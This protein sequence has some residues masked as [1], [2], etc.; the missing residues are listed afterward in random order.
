MKSHFLFLIL[1]SAALQAQVDPQ[2]VTIARDQFG[3]PHIFAKTD[4]EVS[5]GLAWAHAEDDFESLQKVALPSKGLMA[6]V[7]GRGGVGADYAFALFRCREITEEK[8]TTLSP[9]FI[10]LIQGYVQ[11]LNDY[12]QRHP[13]EVLHKDLF[14]ITL[15]DYIAS[16]VLALTVFN[17]GDRALSAIFSNR[18]D[19]LIDFDKMGSNAIA[20]HPSRTNTGE[21]FLAINAHQPNEGPEAFYEAHVNSEENWNAL[22]GLLA[23]GPCILHGVNENLGWAHTV[24]LCDRMDIYQLQMNPEN[25][26]QYLFDGQWIELEKKKIKLSIKGIPIPVKR[27][28][29]WSKYGATMKNDQGVFAIRLGA[30]MEIRALEQ[31]YRMNKAKNHTEFYQAI[32]TQGLSMFNIMYA[33]KRDTIFYINNALMPVRNP[34]PEFNW[35]KTLPGNTSKTLWTSFQRISQL[36]QYINPKSGYLFNTNHSSFLATAKEDN[37]KADDFPR[38]SGWETNENNRSLRVMQMIPQGQIDYNTFKRIKFNRQLPDPMQ[39]LYGVDTFFLMKREDYLQYDTLLQTLQ[40]WDRKGDAGSKGAAVFL[41]IYENISK[42][43]RGKDP[44][45]ITKQQCV[46]ALQWVQ[47][48]MRKYFGTVDLKLGDIQKLVRGDKAYPAPGLP[49]LLAP[50]W[51]VEWKDGRRKITGGDAYVAMVRFPKSGLPIIETVNTYGAS[52]KKGS[53]HFDDQVP[54]FLKQELKP[55]TLDKSKVLAEA[56]R[57]YHPGE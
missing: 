35:K 6:R 30:N 32:S 36:P 2:K 23:G 38:E 34:S 7:Y 56:K 21:A 24:N 22:G 28:L 3:V 10:R 18:V 4:P 9:D 25:P 14:P 19:P 53:P 27:D 26:D 8:W 20:V 44:Q 16:S 17:G 13:E 57:I 46:N 48:Y 5:Y 50:E 1:I 43:M 52:S 55:M 51:G 11:G 42:A 49:D 15:K 40:S 31:W 39:Y 47:E 54:L 41:L 12:A 29:L 45:Q 37:L 33:D